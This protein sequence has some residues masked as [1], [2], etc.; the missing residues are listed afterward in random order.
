MLAPEAMKLSPHESLVG[1][2]W[3]LGFF[4]LKEELKTMISLILKEV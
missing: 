1:Q 3:V 4:S 2:F